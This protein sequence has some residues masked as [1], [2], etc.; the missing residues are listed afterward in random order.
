MVGYKT[1]NIQFQLSPTS[2]P[3]RPW[4]LWFGHRGDVSM[5]DRTTSGVSSSHLS[6]QGDTRRKDVASRSVPVHPSFV[7]LP[8]RVGP[9]A[10]M[11]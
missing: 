3:S 11:V 10:E 4:L 9:H 5:N 2:R 6:G 1:E 7:S 8:S